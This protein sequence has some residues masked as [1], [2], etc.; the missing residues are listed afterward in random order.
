VLPENFGRIT[1]WLGENWWS[2]L[3]DMTNAFQTFH[4]NLAANAVNLGKGI[5]DAIQG[6]GFK[7][8]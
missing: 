1:T 4:V 7:F 2:L 6:K 8:E 5:W 3:K